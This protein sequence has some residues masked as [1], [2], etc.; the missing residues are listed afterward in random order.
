ML[1]QDLLTLF[2]K[3]G[4][5]EAT[6]YQ[7]TAASPRAVLFYFHG[8]GLLYGT[9]DD[10][11]DEHIHFLTDS[12]LMIIACDYPLAPAVG[13]ED[14]ITDAESSVCELHSRFCTV[15]EQHPLPY[16]LWGRSAGAYLCLLMAVRSNHIPP[17]SGVISYYGYGLLT[18]GWFDLP[19]TF[20][21]SLPAVDPGCIDHIS[22]Q[23]LM[24][25]SLDTCYS[26]YVYA[27]Q[28]GKWFQMISKC[29]VKQF[30]RDYT[31]RLSQDFPVPLFCAHSLH[32]PDVPFA[33]FQALTAKY[34]V[35]KY[36][37]VSKQ[38]DFDRSAS[39][40]MLHDLLISTLNFI[41]HHI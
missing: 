17:C 38:H 40:S 9:R 24:C 10:L 23:T 32:D 16:F 21:T 15:D 27:R 33:E 35:Q 5:K 2:S 31:L 34:P 36:I 28:T 1:T 14:I 25:G 3:Y 20:Y 26:L 30:Y 13:I 8:G 19:N 7:N 22:S 12:G 4:K 6:V 37:A 39:Q 18:D 11:P 29:P 41:D